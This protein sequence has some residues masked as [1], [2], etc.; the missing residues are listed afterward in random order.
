M[1][2]DALALADA[3]DVFADRGDDARDFVAEGERRVRASGL[4][5]IVRVAV[6]DAGAVDVDDDLARSRRG[7]GQVALDQRLP[8]SFKTNGFHVE[9]GNG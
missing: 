2:R 6:A 7:V 9:C 8:M 3:V 4:G 5:A 1:Q